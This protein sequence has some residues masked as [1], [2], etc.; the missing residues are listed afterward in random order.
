MQD[1]Y[2]ELKDSKQRV[3]E[4]IKSEEI[5]FAH[6]LDIGLAR[7]EDDIRTVFAETMER[8]RFQPSG[9]PEEVNRNMLLV[10]LNQNNETMVYPGEQAFELLRY[11]RASFG[12][13]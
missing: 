12:F 7:L 10:F 8:H 13:Y 11:L 3:S 1:A 6:T 5:R 2:P 4:V 9:S